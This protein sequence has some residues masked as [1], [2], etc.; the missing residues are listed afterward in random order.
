MGKGNGNGKGKEIVKLTP[1][2]ELSQ[3]GGKA[4]GSKGNGH[5]GQ[6]RAGIFRARSIARHV[7]FL[8]DDTNST[9]ESYGN[10]DSEHDSDVDMRMDN[11]VDAPYGVDLDGDVD[12][13]WDRDDEEEEDDEEED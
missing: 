8:D 4:T 11:D 2:G 13:E 5:W 12:K 6:T 7:K 10:Y 1:R 3:C 9:E